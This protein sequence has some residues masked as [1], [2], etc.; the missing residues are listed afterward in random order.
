L[1]PNSTVL[2]VK[3]HRVETR[4]ALSLQKIQPKISASHSVTGY[5]CAGQKADLSAVARQ[6]EGG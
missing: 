3:P 6:S 2:D 5:C 1:E 4:H